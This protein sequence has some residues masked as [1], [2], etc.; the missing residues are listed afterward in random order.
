MQHRGEPLRP[1]AGRGHAE[2]HAAGLD[3]LLGAADPPR[4]RRLGHKERPG[5]SPRGGQAAGRAEREGDR[6]QATAPGGSKGK[7]GSGCRRPRRG[8]RASAAGATHCPGR[9]PPG[10]GVLPPLPGLL[11]AQQVGQP[12][13]GNRDQPAARLGGDA[14]PR[15]LHRGGEQR[16]L[17]RVLGGVEVPE[18]PDH[19]AGT[20]GARAAQQASGPQVPACGQGQSSSSSR[21]SATGRTSMTASVATGRARATR[22]PSG[23]MR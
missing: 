9:D 6:R 15:P 23:D 5:L 17:D 18:A 11:A 8:Q 13:R 7:A 16:L 2:R 3:A 12:P 1:L 19:R 4:H 14:V 21:E 22:Q 10:R 20:C